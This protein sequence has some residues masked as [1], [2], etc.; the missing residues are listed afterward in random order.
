MTYVLAA[1]IGVNVVLSLG[2]FVSIGG[3][4]VVTGKEV[5]AACMNAV[6]VSLAGTWLWRFIT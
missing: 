6:A 5:F 2:L 3:K 1:S 4:Q